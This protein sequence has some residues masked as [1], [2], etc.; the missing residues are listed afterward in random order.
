MIPSSS[1]KGVRYTWPVIRRRVSEPGN[2]NPSRQA[3]CA[4][5][6]DTEFLLVKLTSLYDSYFC[7]EFYL[8][9]P[10]FYLPIVGVESYCCTEYT[11]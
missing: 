6:L 1:S 10:S 11:H 8:V 5:G 3:T 2:N 7:V 4:T 9:L